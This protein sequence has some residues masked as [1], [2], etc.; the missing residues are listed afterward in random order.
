ME[1]IMNIR[2]ELDHDIAILLL[3]GRM[4]GTSAGGVEE[5]FNELIQ[6]GRTRFVIDLG[7][8]SYISSAGLRIV[9]VAVKKTKAVQGRIIFAALTEQVKEILDMSGFL[10]LL[11]TAPS[12]AE[13]LN[14]MRG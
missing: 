3:E 11:E 7:S 10:P 6:A 14:A 5:R 2:H 8:L 4:D 1:A 9:L 12:R 13:A